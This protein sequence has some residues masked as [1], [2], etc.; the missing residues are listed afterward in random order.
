VA[1]LGAQLARGGVELTSEE[2]DMLPIRKLATM[3]ATVGSLLALSAGSAF[4]LE[5]GVKVEC[6]GACGWINLGQICDAVSWGSTPV[7]IAC[8]DTSAQAIGQSNCGAGV[9]QAWGDYWRS[10]AL[11]A[12]CDD[13]LGYDAVVTCRW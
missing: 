9:C 6:N 12:H 10:D 7:A 3:V 4:A 5:G 11:S 8:D 2:N 1:R 13:G